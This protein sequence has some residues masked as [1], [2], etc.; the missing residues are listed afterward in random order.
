MRKTKVILPGASAPNLPPENRKNRHFDEIVAA[1]LDLATRLNWRI[2][3]VAGK[4]PTTPRGVYDATADPNHLLGWLSLASDRAT[5]I[6]VACGEGFDVVDIDSHHPPE[7][8][9]RAVSAYEG[10]IALTPHGIHLFTLPFASRSA[11]RPLPEIDIRTRGSYVVLPPSMSADGKS[12]AWIASPFDSPLRPCPY[13]L[14][15]KLLAADAG[16]N[17]LSLPPPA[18]VDGVDNPRLRQYVI[19]ALA[20][21]A[22]DVAGAPVGTRNRCLYARAVKAGGYV[23]AGLIDLDAVTSTLAAAGFKAGLTIKETAAT[24][25]S[26][27]KAGMSRPWIPIVR[28]QKQ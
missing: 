16:S 26:G 15:E 22:Q 13:V 1:A 28:P 11:V 21:M 10:P 27:L 18:E 5:G 2:L 4:R 25:K 12:Y 14:R 3:P 19:A 20:K 8:I 24:I 7:W 9:E 17:E 23:A 6:A